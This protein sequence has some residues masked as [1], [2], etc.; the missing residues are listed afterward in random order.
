VCENTHPAAATRQQPNL[1]HLTQLKG[2]VWVI[3]P[4]VLNE[5]R[6]EDVR[7]ACAEIGLRIAKMALVGNGI[8]DTIQVAIADECYATAL[9]ELLARGAAWKVLSVDVPD[10]RIEG[11]I[12]VDAQALDRLPS[13]TDNPER[14][15]LI[16]RNDPGALARAWEAGIV[17]VVSEN[18]PMSTAMLAIMAARLQVSKAVR[19]NVP[20]V[21]RP[22]Q[23]EVRIDRGKERRRET[24]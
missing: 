16:A 10:P 21:P 22:G 13:R 17:S 12:V 2:P 9:R 15:V 20:G 5:Q 3:Y 11:V 24:S 6:L 19:Q 8:M 18:D 14:V 1:G 23:E 4:F 7:L